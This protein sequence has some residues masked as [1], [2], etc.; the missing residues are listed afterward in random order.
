MVQDFT[1]HTHTIEFDGKNSAAEMIAAARHAGFHT[2][3][4]SNHFIVHPD[5]RRTKM[6]GAAVAGG[7]QSMYSSNF[8]EALEK[9]KPHYEYLSRLQA[10]NPDIRILRGMEVDYF[11]S[12]QWRD[13]FARSYEILKPDYLIGAAHFIEY[14]GT[15]CN[16]HDMAMVDAKIRDE[17]LKIYWENVSRLGNVGLF[18]WLAHLDLP[19]K[20][21]LGVSKKWADIHEDTVVSIANSRT[22]VEINTSG[23]HFDSSQPYP[24]NEIQKM[25]AAYHVPVLL[26]D[27]AHNINQIGSKFDVA[28]TILRENGIKNTLSLQKVLDFREKRL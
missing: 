14:G 22:P 6:Y 19:R 23:F 24:C 5:V 27:D 21:G 18:N 20:L 15:I 7:Y 28:A 4:I 8:D 17:M 1:L 16:V 2:I 3:G 9:F 25:L 11:P 12:T 10:Q 13:G 26:S